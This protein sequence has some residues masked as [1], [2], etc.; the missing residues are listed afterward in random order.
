MG[1]GP[2]VSGGMSKGEYDAALAEQRKYE[3]GATSARDAKLAQYEKDRIA[4]EK[5]L[6]QSAKDAEMAKTTAQQDAEAALAAEADAQL[7]EDQKQQSKLGSSFYESLYKGSINNTPT[8]TNLD[9]GST[10]KNSMP[11]LGR[12]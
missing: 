10:V 5:G 1:G 12:M 11:Y 4:A 7:T 3:E 6:L 8:N 9:L 2:S